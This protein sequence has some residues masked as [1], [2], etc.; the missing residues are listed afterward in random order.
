MGHIQKAPKG[1]IAIENNK[2]RI[3][4]RW[5][6]NGKRYPLS[7][8]Y[9]YSPENMHYATIK[10][11]EIELDM[12]KGCFD[13]SLEK[14]KPQKPKPVALLPEK[15]TL[16]PNPVVTSLH[17][18]SDKFKDWTKNIRNINI[19][20]SVDY[21]G[22]YRV[23][24]RWVNIP[25]GEIAGTM[26]VENWSVSTYNRRL[27]M[28]SAFLSWLKDSGIITSNPLLHVS[29]RRTKGQ[30]KQQK[31]NERRIPLQ[32]R[33]IFDFLE[34]MRLDTYCHKCSP[35]KHSFYYTFLKFIFLTGVRNAEA[36]GLRVR[37][38]NFD[39]NTVEISE[40]FAR[41]NK[42][43]HHAARISKDTK[44]G[45][46][47]YL[48]MTDELKELLLKQVHSKN[49][50]DFVFPSPKGLSIDDRML[51]RRVIKPVLVQLKFGNRDLYVARH[52]FGTRAVQQ[53]MALTDV[54]YLMGHTTIKTAI[55]NYVDVSRPAVALPK[56]ALKSS[57]NLKK[58][59]NGDV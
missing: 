56:T 40:A 4:L 25:L 39:L 8:P 32:E 19:D 26:N 47:R 11:A 57:D 54:A 7:L 22:L 27:N 10:V 50:D 59:A 3:R 1:E 9:A 34:A 29:S 53:G 12:M 21:Y 36:V 42:G 17:E 43:T 31:K 15:K 16:P 5:R 35:V 46:V 18:L 2:G 33:E 14:Y 13:T 20:H 24:V 48:P 6:Y 38:I 30:D 23:L 45:N 41:T 28:L 51:Q 37:H 44:A 52:C 58:V 55:N 49:P